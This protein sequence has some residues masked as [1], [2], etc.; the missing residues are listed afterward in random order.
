MVDAT[1]TRIEGDIATHAA[2][3]QRIGNA[4]QGLSSAVDTGGGSI[5]GQTDLI[6][7][8]STK[9]TAMEAKIANL[10]DQNFKAYQAVEATNAELN[11]IKA[12][13][14][15]GFQNMNP[16]GLNPDKGPSLAKLAS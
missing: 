5:V 8:M 10:E 12:M 4:M 13:V 1:V 3:I 14:N 2:E 11:S 6:M 15:N 7:A 9:I 16:P